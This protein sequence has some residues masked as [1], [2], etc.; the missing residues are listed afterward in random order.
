MPDD[1]TP[2]ILRCVLGGETF[3][4]NQ[5]TGALAM[6]KGAACTACMDRLFSVPDLGRKGKEQPY[7]RPRQPHRAFGTSG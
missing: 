3:D 1:M 4:F 6:G 5:D 7:K 2:Q